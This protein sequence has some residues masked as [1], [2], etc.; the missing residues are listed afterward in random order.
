MGPMGV[1]PEEALARHGRAMQGWLR[2]LLGDPHE[3]EDAY[4]EACLRVVRFFDRRRSDDAASLEAW[5]HT[6]A[7]REGFRRLRRRATERRRARRLATEDG[8]RLAAPGPGPST[9]LRERQLDER[10][11]DALFTLVGE[12]RADE[13][14]LLA[15]R[16]QEGLSHKE[17]GERLGDPGQPMAETAVRKRLSRV[18]GKLRARAAEAG[19]GELALG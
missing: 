19:L 14:A 12:L 13:S 8:E 1:T 7:R 10:T 16:F 9:A 18:V 3:A 11:R 15:L 17:I 5:M 2:R 4:R 6:V